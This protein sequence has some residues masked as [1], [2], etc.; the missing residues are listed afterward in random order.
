MYSC[1]R[2]TNATSTLT[3][4]HILHKCTCNIDVWT[5]TQ[6]VHI[7]TAKQRTVIQQY[8][9][10]CWVGC[11]IWYSDEGHR[12]AA[13]PP[14]PLLAVSNVTAHP[15][16][17]SV[18]TSHYLMWHYNC[19]WTQIIDLLG[20]VNPSDRSSICNRPKTSAINHN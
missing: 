20:H 17:V 5:E 4:C 2:Q 1:T 13:A 16:T 3:E 10:R 6:Y 12:R 18:P 7:K 11:Y 8:T 15:S 9:G 19:L 14:S